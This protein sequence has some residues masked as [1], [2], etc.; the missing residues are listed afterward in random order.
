MERY[1]FVIAGLTRN[2][3]G[4][5]ASAAWMPGQARHDMELCKRAAWRVKP[6]MTWSCA[7]AAAWRVKPGMT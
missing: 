7:N 1:W 6:G 4:G 2:P 3:F 5:S